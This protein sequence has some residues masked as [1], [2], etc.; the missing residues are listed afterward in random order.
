[1]VV[2][3]SDKVFLMLVLLIGCALIIVYD[4]GPVGTVGPV[5]RTLEGYLDIWESSSSLG[6]CY[7]QEVYLVFGYYL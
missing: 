6:N 4:M 1:M 7:L 5:G 3:T 2:L